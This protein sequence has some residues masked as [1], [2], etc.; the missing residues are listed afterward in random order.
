MLKWH[1]YHGAPSL[2]PDGSLVL[3]NAD[4]RAVPAVQNLHL[5]SADNY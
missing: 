5:I 4:G 3:A 1:T 2:F